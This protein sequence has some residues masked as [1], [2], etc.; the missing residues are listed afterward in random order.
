M[1]SILVQSSKD[2]PGTLKSTESGTALV[3]SGPVIKRKIRRS[4]VHVIIMCMSLNRPGI[5]HVISF[6]ILNFSDERI[7]VYQWF[8]Q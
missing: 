1:R 8:M 7:I 4:S 3:E 6:T 5:V 2:W